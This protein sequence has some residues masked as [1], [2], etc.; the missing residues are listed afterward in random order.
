MIKNAI[1]LSLLITT[2]AFAFG[3][4]GGDRKAMEYRQG[5]DALGVHYDNNSQQ[6][7]V[8]FNCNASDTTSDIPSDCGCKEGYEKLGNNCLPKCP[9][10]YERNVD[11]K[12]SPIC[13][14][15]RL[16]GNTCCGEGNI[17]VNGIKCCNEYHYDNYGDEVC[18]D[19]SES[20]GFDVWD[21]KCCN[22][23]ETTYIYSEGNSYYG[24]K[25]CHQDYL[26]KDV[27]FG[28][29]EYS[30]KTLCCDHEPDDYKDFKVCWEQ[31]TNCHTNDDCASLGENYY[32][33]LKNNTDYDS[34]YPTSGECKQILPSD[35]T[36]LTIAGL[37]NVRIKELNGT[38]LSWWAANNWCKAQGKN[39]IDIADFQCYY[40]GT[41]TQ[42]TSATGPG[43]CCAQGQTCSSWNSYWND[44]EIKTGSETIVNTK[45]SPIYIKL[46]QIL[47]TKG[48]GSTLFASASPTWNNAYCTRF[49]VD[50]HH[51][52]ANQGSSWVETNRV[53]CK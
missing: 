4:G 16:C 45:Y 44:N 9:S 51:G 43:N 8:D 13:P 38:E 12:C 35:Y 46:A 33:H 11:G 21:L 32:C 18:C 22:L 34:C 39:L 27:G 30:K 7:D 49:A 15:E 17:C 1:L 3:G 52:S 14:E 25:C 23:N 2:S 24:P 41:T 47:G 53:L 40:S 36:D 28:G 26:Y 42:I 6:I 37:G 29:T 31:G 19:A 48:D 10:N 5:V 50:L 20:T